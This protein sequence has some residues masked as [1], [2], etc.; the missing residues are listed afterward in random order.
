MALIFFSDIPWESL[1]QRPQHLAERLAEAMAVLWVEPATLGRRSSFTPVTLG[2]NL[3][4]LSL[5][6]IPY[7]ARNRAIRLISHI[8]SRIVPLRTIL[9]LVQGHLLRRALR[10][11]GM[12]RDQLIC[13]IENFQALFLISNLCPATVLYDCID[14]PF[15]FVDFPP[16]VHRE[17][18]TMLERADLLVATSPNLRNIMQSQVAKPVHIV[19]N[20]V[21]YERFAAMPAERPA[22]LPPQGKPIIGYIGSV[23]TWLDFELLRFLCVHAPNLRVVIIGHDH[24]NTRSDLQTLS[25]FPNFSYLGL[26]PY[27]SVPSYLHAFDVGI[28]PF[29]RS[30]LTAGVN[31]VK[32]YEYSAAGLPIV[33]TD[34]SPDLE[35]FRPMIAVCNTPEDFLTSVHRAILLRHEP[36]H[37]ST[38]QSFARA[39]DWQDKGREILRLLQ[40]HISHSLRAATS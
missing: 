32:L 8:L 29:R 2:R 11:L 28:I 39:H 31:P 13:V 10:T 37:V 6:F 9:T 27:A 12:D 30:A 38:V 22:D 36:Q 17:W 7:N 34:F 40:G 18:H 19:S 1:H 26:R 25:R 3:H 16:H 4:G 21:E 23:Y 5:P 15:G 35:A 14:N 33:A 24:P 20:G